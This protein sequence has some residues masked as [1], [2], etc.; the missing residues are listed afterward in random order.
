MLKCNCHDP[1]HPQLEFGVTWLIGRNPPNPPHR[2]WRI[3]LNPN[4]TNS[5][6]QQ[7]LRLDYILTCDPP[8]PPP[9]Q[10]QL[11]Y[12]KLDRADNC[13]ASK[14]GPV[15]TSVQSHT[16]QCSHSVLRFRGRTLFF[17]R[18]KD[19]DFFCLRIQK[20]L[21]GKIKWISIRHRVTF[22]GI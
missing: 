9:T 10:T 2:N 19:F 21:G 5:S 4:S 20:R 8:K 12:S 18:Q 11:V 13:P 1:T 7:S 17:S 6:V 22:Q 15:C 16:D 14:Q 3:C